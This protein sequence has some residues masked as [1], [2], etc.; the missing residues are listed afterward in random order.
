[1]FVISHDPR[2]S[3]SGGDKHSLINRGLF[4]PLYGVV[5]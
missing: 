2:S 5:S 4:D 1:M 3:A